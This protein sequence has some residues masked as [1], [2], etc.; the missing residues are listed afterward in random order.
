MVHAMLKQ[1][2]GLG[3]P[4]ER[5]VLG[6]FSQGAALSLLAGLTYEKPL[7][8]IVALSGWAMRRDDL[9]ELVKQKQVPIFIGHGES[10]PTVPCT[11]G[12]SAEKALRAAGCTNIELRTYAGLGHSAAPQEFSDLK[13]FFHSCVPE[14]CTKTDRTSMQQSDTPA[15]A[16]TRTAVKLVTNRKSSAQANESA[17]QQPKLLQPQCTVR[18]V[19]DY[20]I[21]SVELP[22]I[23]NF[24]DITVDLSVTELQLHSQSSNGPEKYGLQMKLPKTV[25]PES[26]QAKFSRRRQV[27]EIHA[28]TDAIGP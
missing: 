1:S 21:I 23:L 22:G 11:L 2:E 16:A 4:S 18:T 12:R 6:G 24:D 13:R 27:L 8:G 20:L 7:A 3:F 19:K 5:T 28:P 26:S 9:P 15:R 17:T 10:D 14:E 25:Q